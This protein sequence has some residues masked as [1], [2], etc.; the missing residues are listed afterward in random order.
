MFAHSSRPPDP[1]IVGK[2]RQMWM[3]AGTNRS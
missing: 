1:A 2:R 3:E